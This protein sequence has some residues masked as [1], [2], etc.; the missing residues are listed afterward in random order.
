MILPSWVAEPGPRARIDYAA[1]GRRC[2][3]AEARGRFQVA[4]PRRRLAEECQDALTEDVS[5]VPHRFTTPLGWWTPHPVRVA[6]QRTQVCRYWRRRIRSRPRCATVTVPASVV[7]LRPATTS[8]SA[9][10]TV[11]ADWSDGRSTRMPAC[12]PGGYARMSPQVIGRSPVAAQAWRVRLDEVRTLT[13]HRPSPSTYR[14]KTGDTPE[15]TGGRGTRRT[16]PLG[17]RG[18]GLQENRRKTGT[19]P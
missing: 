5:E 8:A 19:P 17:D 2:G 3:A 1:E 7:R 9:A 14:R 15:P 6:P 12:L 10:A 16:P 18:P 13:C 4:L 11:R